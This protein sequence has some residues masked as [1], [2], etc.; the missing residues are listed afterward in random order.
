L[1]ALVV[2]VAGIAWY[3]KH[4]A[5]PAAV[6]A[7]KPSVAVLPLQNL[8]A[9]PDSSYFSDGMTDEITTKLSKIGSIDVASHS[10]VVALKSAGKSA[11]DIG[12]ELGVRYRLEGSVRK[13]GDQVRINVQLIDS[14][15]GFQVWADDF[16]GEMK[17][18]FSLQEQAALKIAQSL[19]RSP[20]PAID[21]ALSQMTHS[22]FLRAKKEGDAKLM[23]PTWEERLRFERCLNKRS[24]PQC[25]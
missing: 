4:S 1:L 12:K 10:S 23:R 13:S 15:S 18:V 2:A 11:T 24:R 20:L 14:N 8:S 5:A 22:E 16:T 3:Q 6:V 17:D 9:E 7:G 21:P 25:R 19:N